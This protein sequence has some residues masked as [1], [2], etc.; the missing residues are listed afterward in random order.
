MLFKGTKMNLVIEPFVMCNNGLKSLSEL[1]LKAHEIGTIQCDY[2]LKNFA[3]HRLL[4]ALVFRIFGVQTKEEW[5]ELWQQGYFSP[6]KIESYFKTHYDKFDL[7]GNKPFMQDA[8][9]KQGSKNDSV[10][11]LRFF[12]DN[13]VSLFSKDFIG[14]GSRNASQVALE[15]ITHQMFA[16]RTKIGKEGYPE[17]S[18]YHVNAKGGVGL[19]MC[20]KT[21][22]ETILLN[23][24]P[25]P[26]LRIGSNNKSDLPTWERNSQE[27]EIT[28]PIDYLT[29]PTRRILLIPNNDGS[30]T[31]IVYQPGEEPSK[32]IFDPFVIYENT[33][34]GYRPINFNH[35]RY[36]WQHFQSLMAS[37]KTETYVKYSNNYSVNL[38][39][40]DYTFSYTCFEMHMDSKRSKYK[41]VL[42]DN[43]VVP[44]RFLRDD[45]I[46]DYL[47]QTIDNC[48]KIGTSL[49]GSLFGFYLN[50]IVPKG[51]MVRE[52][53][54]QASN[55]CQNTLYDFWTKANYIFLTT[56]P[57][58]LTDAKKAMEDVLKQVKK[59]AYDC[60]GQATRRLQQCNAT[61]Y[62]EYLL[63]G[64]RQRAIM[65]INQTNK[66]LTNET[67]R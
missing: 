10:N 32:E 48:N 61:K 52:R 66:E 35:N 13:D 22:F 27:G 65:K 62:Y 39:P 40:D 56:Y 67:G 41:S 2:P 64:G 54:R 3:V 4:V 14:D 55:L 51:K 47:S 46:K 38:I 49:R 7:T 11:K 33:K 18:L 6:I 24:P 59:A 28:G 43:L 23:C 42:Q 12:T 9:L 26:M 44:V 16:L 34:D 45:D 36:L 57:V 20:G 1:L 5:K 17:P 29:R 8:S 60:L 19:L 63:R 58:F 50:N 21:L 25:Y 30:F 53:N 37:A 31:N 15:L